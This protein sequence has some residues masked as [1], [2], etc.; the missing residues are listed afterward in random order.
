LKREEREEREAI[1]AEEPKSRKCQKYRICLFNNIKNKMINNKE[2]N[3][4]K[5]DDASIR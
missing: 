2:N 4:L 3:K 5:K 1:R